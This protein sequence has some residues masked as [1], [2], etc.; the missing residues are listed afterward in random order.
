ME[1]SL[2]KGGMWFGGKQPSEQDKVVVEKIKTKSVIPNPEQ[3]PHLFAW[4]SLASKFSADKM[5][6]WK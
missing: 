5:N 2:S 1:E 6:A 3:H 4:Y